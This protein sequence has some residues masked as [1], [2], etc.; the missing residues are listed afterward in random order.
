[1]H[2]LALAAFSSNR[3]KSA[4]GWVQKGLKVDANDE[5]LRRLRSR[6]IWKSIRSFFVRLIGSK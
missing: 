3:Y 5:E 4:W 6:L 1:M 2:N